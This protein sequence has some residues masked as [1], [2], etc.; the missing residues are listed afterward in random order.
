MKDYQITESKTMFS[1]KIVSVEHDTITLPNG[2]PAMRENVR[3][4]GGAAVLPVD[5]DGNMVF[6]RQYRHS[7]REMMLEIPA[8]TLN[9]EETHEECAIREL[10]E[11]VGYKAGNIRFLARIN[12]SPGYCSESIYIYLATR[13]VKGRQ[14]L[15]EEEFI[16][17]E[18]YTPD[19]AVQMI[20]DG[21]ITDGK[22]VM[23]ILAY[24]E[25]DPGGC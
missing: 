9:A 11:E 16:E 21:R 13:L 5:N 7:V 8:G 17:I 20:F 22:T 2:R 14:N 4:A 18:T 1:G 23:A 19:E 12:P 6:V 15:D 25:L 10:E 3:H 24:R